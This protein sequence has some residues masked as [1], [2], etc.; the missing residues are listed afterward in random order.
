[1]WVNII[2]DGPPALTLGLEPVRGSLME[3]R[4][5]GRN[6]SI[7]TRNML[8]RILVNGLFISIVF[9]AQ[10][11][12]NF[13][14]AAPQ[15]LST[16]LFTLFVVFQLF[17]AFNSRELSNRSIFRSLGSNKLMLA[18][19]ALTFALQVVI[20]QFGGVVFGT[21]PLPLSMW[22]KIVAVAFTVVLVSELVKL[23]WRLISRKKA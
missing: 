5:V 1:M 14:G 4:P 9:M 16:V 17:N 23:V 21:V 8:G 6:A 13:L 15:Q 10:Y 7:V 22:A 2:M 19:F 3:R 12:T 18:V 11:F 20:T